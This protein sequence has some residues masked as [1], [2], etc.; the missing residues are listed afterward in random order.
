MAVSAIERANLST[1]AGFDR[2]GVVHIAR[3]TAP[4]SLRLR[5]PVGIFVSGYQRMIISGNA[6]SGS[7]TGHGLLCHTSLQ[8]ATGNTAAG[9]ETAI[10]VC[11]NG[12]NVVA[13]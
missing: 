7:G 13:P 10:Q 4:A 1:G 9:F 8:F 5:H 2:V 6:L 3:L 12:G 11:G